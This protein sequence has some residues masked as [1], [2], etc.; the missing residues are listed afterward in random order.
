MQIPQLTG[1]FDYKPYEAPANATE[2]NLSTIAALA[3][4]A[5][6]LERL[7][8]EKVA[9]MAADLKLDGIDSLY[10]QHALDAINGWNQSNLQQLKQNDKLSRLTLSGPQKIESD[11]KYRELLTGLNAMRDMSSDYKKTIEQAHKDVN[12]EI[13]T[14]EDYH[15]FEDEFNTKL[16]AAKSIEDLPYAHAVYNNFL[17]KN[18][19]IRNLRRDKEF[20][21]QMFGLY[22]QWNYTEGGQPTR[23][24]K[25]VRDNIENSF[26]SGSQ[27]WVAL[28][29]MLQARNFYPPSAQTEEQRKQ[30]LTVASKSGWNPKELSQQHTSIYNNFGGKDKINPVV[31]QK[32][33][34]TYYD[35]SWVSDINDIYGPY[36]GRYTTVKVGPDGKSYVYMTQVVNAKGEPVVFD[37]NLTLEQQK[38]GA[39][40]DPN[41]AGGIWLPYNEKVEAALQGNNVITANIGGKKGWYTAPGEQVESPHKPGTYYYNGKPYSYDDLI[42]AGVDVKAAIKAKV[43]TVK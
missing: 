5:G 30:F 40:S 34:E 21:D 23:S 39:K 10:R 11:R 29:N 27:Q 19:Q 17:Y 41:K 8:A 38:M 36:K 25:N 3:D 26:P 33:G 15:R 31:Q 9:A 43:V 13:L 16:N 42:N 32:N 2:N 24:E 1:L 28:D 14:P 20:N 35:F 22:K 12:D 7:Q 4:P 18:P 37:E 6:T